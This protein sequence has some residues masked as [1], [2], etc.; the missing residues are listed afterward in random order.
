MLAWVHQAITAEWELLES[1]FG[2]SSDGRMVGSVRVSNGDSE[3]EE[4]IQEL[5]DTCMGK[6]CM[7]L[8]VGFWVTIFASELNQAIDS[9]ATTVRSQEN[10]IISY[11]IANLLQ[12]YLIMMCQ[13][14]GENTFFIN[15]SFRVLQQDYQHYDL[16]NHS[17]NPPLPILDH[18]QI[19]CN[20]RTVYQ[21]SLISED[22]TEQ[23]A[24]FKKILDIMVDP[25][26][27]MCA[28]T[29]EEKKQSILEPFSF[30]HEKQQKVQKVIEERETMLTD[31]HEPLSHIPSTQPTELQAAL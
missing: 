3:E 28:T 23:V 5:M 4:W 24:S 19:L 16:N 29:S 17:L 8:K 20:I 1:L 26:V 6:L 10:S 21:T 7:P 27:E 13:T 11:K 18:A 25:A 2:L 31:E 14:I 30:M 15:D 22:N 9:G 12:F